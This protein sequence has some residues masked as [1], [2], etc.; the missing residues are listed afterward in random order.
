MKRKS[1]KDQELADR[2]YLLRAWH[3]WHREQLKDAL[4]GVHG[5]VLGRLIGELKELRSARE[6][7]E[8][9]SAQDWSVVDPDTRAVALHQVNRA[10][11]ALRE[12][13][14]LAPIDDPLPGAPASAFQLIKA[15]ITSSPP[16]A[17]K[18]A[19][20]SSANSGEVR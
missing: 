11:T 13:N 19:E 17:G 1:E 4:A 16:C 12:C 9:I 7:V 10:I 8:C 3:R 2:A 5:A 6:L 14:G 15:I 20:V 18:L